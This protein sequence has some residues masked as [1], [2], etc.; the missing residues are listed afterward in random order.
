MARIA[1]PAAAAFPLAVK[2]LLQSSLQLRD[3]HQQGEISEP[4]LRIATGRLEA[5]LDRMLEK[6]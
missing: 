4:G 6:H 1:S 2:G 5:Q 3:R